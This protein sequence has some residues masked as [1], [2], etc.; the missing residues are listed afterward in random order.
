MCFNG[1]NWNFV[2]NILPLSAVALHSHLILWILFLL[3]WHRA[4]AEQPVHNWRV[5]MEARALNGTFWER[6][7]CVC[8]VG[9]KRA[10]KRNQ[11]TNELKPGGVFVGKIFIFIM[12]NNI[13]Q[14]FTLSWSR[15]KLIY[16][17]CER[18]KLHRKKPQQFTLPTRTCRKEFHWEFPIGG[19]SN[20]GSEMPASSSV[21]EKCA[22]LLPASP[23]SLKSIPAWKINKN[24]EKM[25]PSARA[26]SLSDIPDMVLMHFSLDTAAR[27]FHRR[28]YKCFPPSALSFQTFFSPITRQNAIELREFQFSSFAESLV[29]MMGSRFESF[30]VDYRG[31][32]SV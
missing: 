20:S 7:T 8:G 32:G 19:S 25:S 12:D 11:Q 2:F 28:L 26:P 29:M 3:K 4:E 9:L 31:Y 21:K 22:S 5:W 17:R 27:G 16:R 14:L 23:C 18:V 24:Y 10:K 15:E 30:V 6:H 1:L 13:I